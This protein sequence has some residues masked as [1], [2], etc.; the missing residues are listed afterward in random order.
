MPPVTGAGGS[1]RGLPTWQEHFRKVDDCAYIGPR[2]QTVGDGQEMLLG[3]E[4]DIEQISNLI[5]DTPLVVL[6]GA[7]GVGKSSLV[8]NGLV[9]HLGR[10]GF[11]VLVARKWLELD[12]P[13]PDVEALLTKLL[14]ITHADREAPIPHDGID[15]GSIGDNPGEF[16]APSVRLSDQLAAR[17]EDDLSAVIVLDQFE[18]LLRK[19]LRTAARVVAWT[20]E[21]SY[22]HAYHVV[23]SLR[24]DSTHLLDPLL[25]GRGHSGE[26]GFIR[27]PKPFSLDRI[28]LAPVRDRGTIEEIIKTVKAPPGATVADEVVDAIATAWETSSKDG[29]VPS[30]LELQATLYSLYFLAEQPTEGSR[31]LDESV[32]ERFLSEVELA[33]GIFAAGLRRA[34][35]LKLEHLESTSTQSGLDAYLVE[36]TV[37]M[38]RRASRLL[39]SGGYKVPVHERE[40][41]HRVLDRERE[42]LRI[43]LDREAAE[44][45]RSLEE[46]VRGIEDDLL[47]TEDVLAAPNPFVEERARVRGLTAGPMMGCSAIAALFEEVRRAVFAIEWLETAG[48]L[49]RELEGTLLLVHDGAGPALGAWAVV[50]GG[51]EASATSAAFAR[52]Q[53]VAASGDTYDWGGTSAVDSWS[54]DGGPD[55]LEIVAQLSWRHCRIT[56]RFRSVIFLNCDFTGSL[57]IDCELQGVTFVNCLLDDVNFEDCVLSGGSGFEPIPV[58]DRMSEDAEVGRLA[59]SFVV[60]SDAQEVDHF[61]PYL[62]SAQPVHGRLFFSDTSGLPLGLDLPDEGYPG[63]ILANLVPTTTSGEGLP[64]AYPTA[65]PATGGV[66]MIGGRVCF[67]TLFRLSSIDGSTFA[68]HHVSGNGVDLVV[69][70]PVEGAQPS[71]TR[72]EIYDGAVRGLSV[73]PH[74]PHDG[75]GSP[76]RPSG[77][78]RVEVTIDKSLMQ[79][80]YFADGLSGEARISDSAVIMLINA[81]DNANFPVRVRESR[82]QFVTN[83]EQ[84]E[85]D[86]EPTLPEEA[87]RFE[88]VDAVGGNFRLPN[89]EDLVH[90]LQRMDYRADPAAW[91]VRQRARRR[92]GSSP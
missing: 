86:A 52:R 36:G 62:R 37:E 2:P 89:R 42:G 18:E 10:V 38:V 53:F 56:G 66:T 70:N 41:V 75:S 64:A 79:N 61:R 23:I 25:R 49:K 68:M 29:D 54:F 77:G 92:P 44:Q 85:G 73:S 60:A 17:Y 22:E 58:T 15:L 67:L 50:R 19:D 78:M 51:A 34:V 9:G 24:S 5:V 4:G 47:D 8:M 21:A 90:D 81:G 32:L 33:S 69:G 14:L 3:R 45:T 13:T 30:L 63:R 31:V 83:V 57:F 72:L 65:R 88:P 16:V 12:E 7:S 59:P 27:G 80:I 28:E 82:Y 43:G 26:A 20:I 39:S 48:L 91:E 74:Q 71:H 1:Q 6:S 46:V 76:G 87:R 84:L 40:L 11:D 55:G 35:D